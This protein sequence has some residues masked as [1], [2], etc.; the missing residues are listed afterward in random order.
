MK[1][2]KKKLILYTTTFILISAGTTLKVNKDKSIVLLNEI[3]DY[4]DSFTEDNFLI[5]AHRGFSSLE[6]ENTSKA[7]MLAEEKD[8]IDC[9]EVDARMTKD[10]KIVL[11]HNSYLLAEGE[12]DV[13]VSNSYYSNIMNTNLVYQNSNFPNNGIDWTEKSL[14]NERNND[15]IGQKY[16]LIDLIEG[17]NLCK[18]KIILLDLKF[19]NNDDE[20]I[21]EL[22][23]ELK[24]IN[25]DN[26][27]FQ[28]TDTKALLS[29]QEQTNFKCQ[30]LIDSKYDFKNIND[31]NYFGIKKSL[32][33]Y[34]IVKKLI[35]EG[36]KVAVWTINNSKDLNNVINT[37]GEYYKDVL[38]IT[39][40]PDLIATKL[41]YKEKE[42]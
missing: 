24:D 35:D 5:A 20:F 13:D 7:I 42:E 38:Y 37:L 32:I 29:L 22:I 14:I 21:D 27:I 6:I 41:Y 23:L 8:Y 19:Q 12:Y 40:Y 15:L 31:F 25:T 34:D 17:I 30:L 26:I 4:T 28:S 3:N 16:N 11:S 2:K 18:D 36:K 9:I 1:K 33:S 39:D 10:G